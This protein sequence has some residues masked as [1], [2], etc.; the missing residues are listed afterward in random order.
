MMNYRATDETT[1]SP[2]AGEELAIAPPAIAYDIEIRAGGR[3]YFVPW[4]DSP[5]WI[6][7]LASQLETATEI[8]LAPKLGHADRLPKIRQPLEPGQKWILYS[9]VTGRLEN[10][11]VTRY[12]RIYA[13]GYEQNG[14]RVI[15]TVDHDTGVKDLDAPE[16]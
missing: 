4:G 16:A 8:T 3:V 14:R 15:Q 2:P 6:R 7:R 10:G 11:H 12:R 9:R 5:G 1:S 13:L